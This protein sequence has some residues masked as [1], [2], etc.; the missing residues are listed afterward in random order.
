MK[1]TVQKL[2][3]E[4]GMLKHSP[5]LLKIFTETIPLKFEMEN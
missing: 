4:Q 1:P 2:I 3:A 5:L